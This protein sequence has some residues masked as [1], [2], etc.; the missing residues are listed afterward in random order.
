MTYQISKRIICLANSRKY[1]GRCIAGKEIVPASEEHDPL[2]GPWIRPVSARQSEEVSEDERQFPDGSDPKILDVV[3]I[4]LQAARPKHYQRENWLIDDQQY[5]TKAGRVNVASLAQL[6]DPPSPLWYDGTN[7][8]NGMNDQI[9]LMHA[10]NLTDS[11]R[12]IHVD[13]LTLVVW[14]PGAPF[15]NHK[16]RVQGRFQHAKTNYSLWV[17]DPTIESQYLKLN[18][19]QYA[20]GEC[21]LTI[22]LGEPLNGYAYKLIAAI[23]KP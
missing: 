11:L 17:T 19:G 8:Y 5:W 9:P 21:Y 14:A 13:T 12:L 20:M 18:D 2:I 16:R 22:S 4:P 10:F 23:I 6:I 15:G 3:D 7:T 1:S